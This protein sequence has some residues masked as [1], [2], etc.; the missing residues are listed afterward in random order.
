[1]RGLSK[2]ACGEPSKVVAELVCCSVFGKDISSLNVTDWNNVLTAA[3]D[4]GLTA[5]CKDAL[6]KLP[7]GKEPDFQTAL[8]REVSARIVNGNYDRLQAARKS[9]QELFASHGIRIFRIWVLPLTAVCRSC[10]F[11]DHL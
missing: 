11:L 8:R 9:L 4:H 2:N 6:D 3:S 5:V 1:M 7:P 10:R